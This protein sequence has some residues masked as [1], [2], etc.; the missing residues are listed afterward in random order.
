M[1]HSLA[2]SEKRKALLNL[3]AERIREENLKK[4]GKNR[5][6]A[7]LPEDNPAIQC[8]VLSENFNEIANL[9][10]DNLKNFESGTI[11]RK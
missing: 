10:Y 5:D 11:Q 2:T 6:S 1:I 7:I 4:T 9:Y 8:Y 3:L